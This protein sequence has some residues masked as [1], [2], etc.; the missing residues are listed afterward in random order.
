MATNFKLLWA[1]V[2]GEFAPTASEYLAANGIDLITTTSEAECLDRLRR[3]KPDA[4]LLDEELPCRGIEEFILQ[5]REELPID[6]WPLILVTCDEPA[7]VIS[8]RTGVPAPHCV[9]KPISLQ[10]LLPRLAASPDLK[11]ESHVIGERQR[12]QSHEERPGTSLRAT[13]TLTHT[14]ETL[15]NAV[16]HALEGTGCWALRDVTVSVT[17]GCVRLNGHVNTYYVK[18]LAQ[19]AVFGVDGVECVMNGLEVE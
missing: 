11:R 6:V 5:L 10:A 13:G 2:G 7:D 16:R 15:A 8:V 18:Q 3:W 9:R 14:D 1:D 12:N 4:L 17:N 19:N